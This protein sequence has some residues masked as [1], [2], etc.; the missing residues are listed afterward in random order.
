MRKRGA[1]DDPDRHE[2]A[3]PPGS[4]ATT[5]AE[6]PPPV[7]IYRHQMVDWVFSTLSEPA[8][9]I[10]RILAAG[11]RNWTLAGG[12][13]IGVFTVLDTAWLRRL[14]DDLHFA[15]VLLLA[16][17]L[18]PPLG[19]LLVHTLA[20]LIGVTGRWLGGAARHRDLCAAVASAVVPMTL[21][22]PALLVGTMGGLYSSGPTALVFG[23]IIVPA[24]TWAAFIASVS[25]AEVQKFPSAWKGLG[26]LLLANICTAAVLF[27]L[28]LAVVFVLDSFRPY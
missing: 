14:S 21:V 1:S 13:A 17:T 15:V 11:S 23:V 25:I 9:T 12:V 8:P 16:C 7:Y 18:G 5:P 22:L 4:G 20:A 2:S 27:G 10:R 26:N 6:L 3:Q 19:I 28:F 24:S